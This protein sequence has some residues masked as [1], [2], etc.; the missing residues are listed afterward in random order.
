[1]KNNLKK[2]KIPLNKELIDM[3]SI[4]ISKE[5][6]EKPKINNEIKKKKNN[7]KIINN[8]NLFYNNI[9]SI[10]NLSY[11]RENNTNFSLYEVIFNFDIA[12]SNREGYNKLHNI[13]SNNFNFQENEKEKK[14]QQTLKIDLDSL[15]I[16]SE[17]INSINDIDYKN[18]ETIKIKEKNNELKEENKTNNL[19]KIQLSIE[20]KS[21]KYIESSTNLITTKKKDNNKEIKK[22]LKTPKKDPIINI[23]ID[24]KEVSKEVF[25]E[26]NFSQFKKNLFPNKKKREIINKKILKDINQISNGII[27]P[28]YINDGKFLDF[29]DNLTQPN[30]KD[31]EI[32][33][34]KRF[35]KNK[36][37]EK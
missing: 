11:Q 4:F 36:T 33:H 30:K 32:I 23:Q 16:K 26:K 27:P 9:I 17:N 35:K 29:I 20:T 18:E 25:Y 12:K 24:L 1:M 34:G 5:N 7:D 37:P 10:L 15:I 21:E 3:I 8:D 13:I 6:V 31:D 2:Y 22:H 19:K 28:N 14:N